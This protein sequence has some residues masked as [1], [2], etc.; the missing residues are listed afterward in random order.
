MNDELKNKRRKKAE[1]YFRAYT[2]KIQSLDYNELPSAIFCGVKFIIFY[3]LTPESSKEEFYGL[4]NFI[5]E[6]KFLMKS[7]PLKLIINNFPIIKDYN[8]A[9][10]ESKDYFSTQEYLSTININVPIQEEIDN[11]LWNYYN[12]DL[13]NFC[14][15]EMLIIDKLR[16]FEGKK[17]LLESFFEENHLDVET[18]IVNKKYHYLYNTKTHKISW[19]KGD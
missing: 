10:F 15:K 3:D 7:L 1:C 13:M 16:K 18:Y 9:K 12:H 14:I 6:V 2:K 8:G 17:G 19:M 4:F 11:F 5:Q